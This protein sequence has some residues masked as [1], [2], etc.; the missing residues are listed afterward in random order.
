[1]SN[2]IL[3]S[4]DIGGTSS[5]AAIDQAVCPEHPATLSCKVCDMTHEHK[6]PGP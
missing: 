6:I 1:M 5:L 4:K 3:T 2:Y